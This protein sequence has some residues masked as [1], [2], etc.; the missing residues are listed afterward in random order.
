[1]NKLTCIILG[2]VVTGFVG[3]QSFAANTDKAQNTNANTK[4]APTQN[5]MQEGANALVETSNSAQPPTKDRTA[6]NVKGR[7]GKV[8]TESSKNAKPSQLKTQERTE[9]VE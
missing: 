5:Q 9:T 8:P 6:R 7:D 3:A 1:M 4:S 2:S